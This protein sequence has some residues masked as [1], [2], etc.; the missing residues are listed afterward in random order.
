MSCSVATV[1]ALAIQKHLH[2][3]Q[4]LSAKI[5]KYLHLIVT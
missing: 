4:N 5:N 1:I 2:K 3:S